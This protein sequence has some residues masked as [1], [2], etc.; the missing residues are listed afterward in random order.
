MAIH[1]LV[2][3]KRLA[4]STVLSIVWLFIVRN[5]AQ[6]IADSKLGLSLIYALR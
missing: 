6:Y 2:T 1:E 3:R 5:G 4:M